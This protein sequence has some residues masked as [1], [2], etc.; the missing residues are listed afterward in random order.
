MQEAHNDLPRNHKTRGIRSSAAIEE[1]ARNISIKR[2][3]ARR[4]KRGSSQASAQDPSHAL[5]FNPN[6]KYGER[7]KITAANVQGM[8]TPAAREELEE[9]AKD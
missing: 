6:M 4:I 1:R 5:T 2:F 3:S 7:L 8:N 9:Y